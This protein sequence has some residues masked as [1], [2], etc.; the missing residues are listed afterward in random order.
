MQPIVVIILLAAL[1]TSLLRARLNEARI[2]EATLAAQR[3]AAT[4]Q[5]IGFDLALTVRQYLKD[6]D[7]TSLLLKDPTPP[8]LV[9]ERTSLSRWDQFQ[10]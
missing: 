3:R 6:V 1:L 2:I 5:E 7:E 10:K 8:P 9:R 4:L